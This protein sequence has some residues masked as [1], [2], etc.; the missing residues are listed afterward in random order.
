MSFLDQEIFDLYTVDDELM[1]KLY[2]ASKQA[3]K[4]E[5]IRGKNW[6]RAE[7]W[8]VMAC[9]F[10]SS[11]MLDSVERFHDYDIDIEV[12]Q[13][14]YISEYSAWNEKINTWGELK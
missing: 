1:G 10:R 14:V 5:I 3:F 9:L 13:S 7:R 8:K 4:L 6:R 12:C 2:A 11:S